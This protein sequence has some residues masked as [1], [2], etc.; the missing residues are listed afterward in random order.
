VVNG[1]DGKPETVA[2]HMLPAMLLNEVQKQSRVNRQLVR[3]NQELQREVD[4]L[5]QKITQVDALTARMDALERRAHASSSE[6]LA[7]VMH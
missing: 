3:N 1:A 7:V 4:A 5:R 6:R 2:Y